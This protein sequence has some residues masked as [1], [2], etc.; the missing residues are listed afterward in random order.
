MN[1]LDIKDRRILYQLDLNSRQSLSQIGKKV[2]LRKD[3]VSYRIKRMQQEGI[4]TSFWTL[5]DSYKLGYIVFRFYLVY[6]YVTP[7][8]K[9]KII[10]YLVKDKRTWVVESIIGKYDLGVFIW[11]K[12]IKDFYQFWEK[13]LDAYGDYFADKIFSIYVQAYSYPCS[14]LLPDEYKESDRLTYE[15]TGGGPEVEIDKYDLSLLN[16]LVENTRISLVDI[17]KQL[18]SST[19]MA[20]SRLKKLVKNNVIQAFRVGVDISKFGLKPFK[21]DIHLQ[22]HIQRKPIMEYIKHHPN[23]VF[24]STSAG[25]SDLE[26]EFDLEDS[27]K[28]HQILEHIKQRFPNAIRKY[29]Y[30]GIEQN[31]KLRCL[32][33]V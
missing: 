3:I 29:D 6:Q 1:T 27:D 18:H 20:N 23:L 32:P 13:L 31:H 5:V 8:I 26:L 24:I 7:E 17:A 22:E 28:V 25:V 12:N 4:I 30:I 15:I 33:E 9:N 19:Q 21:V 10:D 14:Y 11:V 16:L 2:R